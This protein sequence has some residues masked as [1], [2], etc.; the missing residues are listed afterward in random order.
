M[1]L[2]YTPEAPQDLRDIQ[3][4]I[5]DD[6]GNPAASKKVIANILKACSNLKTFPLL[7]ADLSAKTGRDT[8][9]RF[10][11]CGKQ[12]AFYRVENSYISVIRIID[13]RTNYLKILLEE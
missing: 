13:G 10:I 7:G 6:L 2:R 12:L 11:V 4:Y 8:D 1:K 5:S 9:L 3:H